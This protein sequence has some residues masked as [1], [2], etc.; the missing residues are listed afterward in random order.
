MI[1]FRA[2]HDCLLTAHGR[3]HWWPASD[4]FEIMVGAVLVQR[5]AWRNAEMAVGELKRVSLLSPEALARVPAQSLESRIRSAGF[6]RMKARRLSGLARFVVDEGGLDLLAAQSTG[7]LRERLLG[8]DGI[9]PETADTMLLYA[10]GR[11]VVVI[12]EYL[13]RL[14]K[15]LDH[16]S[17]IPEDAV[18][19]RRVADEISDAAGL[20]EL[21]ALVVEHG[22]QLCKRTPH[23]RACT[24]RR[25]CAFAR[26]NS[27]SELG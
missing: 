9:G 25:H 10:F 17:A 8:L 12:D 23:C 5:T 13:R 1:G 24:L 14:M 3:Q 21:H 7:R 18:L 22:K 4:R 20:N 2:I 19:R 15:R 27:D 26:S 6:F 16:G 11:P